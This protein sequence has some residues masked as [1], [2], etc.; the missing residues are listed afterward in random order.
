MLV[1]YHE[2]QNTKYNRNITPYLT[3]ILLPLSIPLFI[4]SPLPPLITSPLHLITPF[5]TPDSLPSSISLSSPLSSLPPST[6][7][8]PSSS[9]HL[10]TPSS[11]PFFY[12]SLRSIR[13]IRWMWINTKYPSE[14]KQWRRGLCVIF[15]LFYFS[16]SLCGCSGPN[17]WEDPNGF[18]G[19]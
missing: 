19:W 5:P 15:R 14:R 3:S 10:L 6:S 11:L 7:P 2:I 12:F 17:N 9:P 13:W 1:R 16:R 18:A 8:P 4:L